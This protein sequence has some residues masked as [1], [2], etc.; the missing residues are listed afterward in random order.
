MVEDLYQRALQ[1]IPAHTAVLDRSGAIILVND[2]WTA[3]A[4]CNGAAGSPA[5]TVGANYL[6]VCRKAASTDADVDRALSGINA[7]LDGSLPLFEIEYP[8]H[9]PCEHRWFSMT[10]AP[11]S[12]RLGGAIVSHS[13]I[14]ARV[15]AEQALR[16]S[17]EQALASARRLEAVGQVAGGVAH[18]FNNLLAVIAGNLEL[19]EDGDA[20]EPTRQLIRRARDAAEKGRDLNGRLLSLARKRALAPQ[21]LS[22]NW[23][24]EETAKLLTSTLGEHIAVGMDLAADLWMTLSDP[25][26]IDSALLNTAANARDAMPKGGR[27]AIATSNVTLDA[28]SAATL[29]PDATPRDYVRLSIADDGAGMPPEILER[30]M[31]P[32][33]TT[34]GAAGSGLGLA[35]VARFAKQTGGFITIASALGQGCIVS[36]Y[37]PRCI[38]EPLVLAD[39]ARAVSRGDGDL[40]LVVEDDDQVREVTLKRLEALGYTVAEAKT[41]SE[42]IEWLKSSTPVQLVLSDIVMPGG[43]TGYDVA[44]WLASNKPEI[45]VILCSGYNEGD[46]GADVQSPNCDVVVLGKPFSRDQLARALSD[47]LAPSRAPRPH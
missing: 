4:H 29:H 12:Q 30:A 40:V 13:N 43:M 31:E 45:R 24:V 23:R 36:L 32:Y 47:A 6:E 21:R 33:F 25:G 14:T 16:T 7:V 18:D 28:T 9:S 41:G 1:A 44:R 2:A 3:F 26:E 11:L 17:N 20:D 46:R 38:L 35:S 5:V 15:M 8:C 34:K 19:A 39:P 10:V 22:V 42:A 27:I 37:L